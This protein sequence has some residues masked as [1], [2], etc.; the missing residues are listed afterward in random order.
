MLVYSV[1]VN[2]VKD[3]S[4]EWLDWMKSI[5]IPEVMATGCFTNF[6]LCKVIEPAQEDASVTYNVQYSCLK[7]ET[8]DLYFEEFAP[9]LQ[10]KHTDRYEGKF[11]AVRSILIDMT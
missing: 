2:I 5:H 1:S 10:K 7:P 8:L 11:F 6:K 4:Q 3:A 9:S